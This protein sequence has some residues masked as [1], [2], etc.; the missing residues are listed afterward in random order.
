MPLA[1]RGGTSPSARDHE[2]GD[3]D[4]ADEIQDAFGPHQVREPEA[5]TGEANQGPGTGHEPAPRGDDARDQEKGVGRLAQ[6]RGRVEDEPRMDGDEDG[7]QE[8][9]LAT[10]DSPGES[11][12]GQDHE[13]AEERGDPATRRLPVTDER[14]GER[15]AE[16]VERMEDRV[17]GRAGL[18]ELPRD[19][20]VHDAVVVDHGEELGDEEPERE[21]DC[22]SSQVWAKRGEKR[23]APTRLAVRKNSIAST[24][25]GGPGVCRK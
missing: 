1:V 5:Q 12:R 2:D 22:A 19:R 18:A 8:G 6:D 9:G 14:L 17:E 15:D 3:G 4:Q 13:R 20:H 16:R 10:H 11:E 23:K 25:R 7:A 24:E 21:R